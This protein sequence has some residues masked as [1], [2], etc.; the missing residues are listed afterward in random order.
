P[1]SSTS[2][3]RR[4]PAGPQGSTTTSRSGRLRKALTGWMWIECRLAFPMGS[5]CHPARRP[6]AGS[7]PAVLLIVLVRILVRRGG[8]PRSRGPHCL[9]PGG[10]NRTRRLRLGAGVAARRGGLLRD[11]R[12]V[13]LLQR[14]GLL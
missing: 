11:V 1:L 2:I 8:R 6:R 7:V 5:S 12:G 14:G 3:Q 9:V 4:S 10:R 13:R